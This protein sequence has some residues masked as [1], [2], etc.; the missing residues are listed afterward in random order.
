[1]RELRATELDEV[2][3]GVIPWAGAA[4]SGFVIGAVT[5][6]TSAHLSGSSWQVT[7]A[8]ATLGGLAGATGGVATVSTG[9]LRAVNT[10]RSIGYGVASNGVTSSGSSTAD[11]DD[12]EKVL[13]K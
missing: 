7:L 2:S 12:M 13:E 1:M 9:A 10:I 11:V 8:S 5:S 4:A 6:G 3:G